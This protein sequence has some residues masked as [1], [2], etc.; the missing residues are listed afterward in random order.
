MEFIFNKEKLIELMHDFYTLTKIRIV[1]FD[2]NFNR[3]A[4]YPEYEVLLCNKI[5]NQNDGNFLCKQSDREACMLCASKS[6]LHI[7]KCHAGLIEAVSPIKMN[8]ITLGYIMFGQIIEK[9][10]KKNNKNKIIEYI[11]KYTENVDEAENLFS[12]LVSKSDKQIRAAAKIMESCACYLCVRDLVQFD[13]GDLIVII[14]NY[15]NNN[16]TEELSVKH[17]CDKFDISK[18]KLYAL[19]NKVYGMG[20]AQY[21]RKKKIEVAKKHLKQG[22]S[23]SEASEKAG[24]YD[25]NYF[26]KIFK[27]ETGILPSKYK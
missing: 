12:S 20:I 6:S 21:I 19:S 15:I 17:L 22:L 11:S 7:Y 1:I 9:N 23:V 27:R 18:N 10:D 24:F 5:K 26:S 14:D 3:V 16:I 25:Y 8:D 13:T 2:I 4:A